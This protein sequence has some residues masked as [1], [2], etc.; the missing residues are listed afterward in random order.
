MSILTLREIESDTLKTDV[1]PGDSGLKLSF[2]KL[3]ATQS[4]RMESGIQ[5]SGNGKVLSGEAKNR[6]IL[7]QKASEYLNQ[8]FQAIRNRRSFNLEPGFQ[9]IENIA[10]VDHL[11]DEI[12]LLAIHLDDRFKYAIH[13]SVNVAVYSVKLAANLGFDKTRQLEI[14]MAGLLHDVGMAVIPDKIIYKQEPLS[15]QEADILKQRPQYSYKILKT[16]G[17]EHAYLAECAAQVYER[18]DGSGYPNGLKAEEINEYAQIIGLLDMYEALIHSRPRRDKMTH[19]SAVKEIINT[20]KTRFQRRHLKAIL[21][22]FTA[23]PVQSYVKLNSDAI[24]RVIETYPDQPM[25][26]KLK[27]IYD[28]QMR[29]VLTDRIISL[30]ENPLLN[31]IDSVPEKEIRQLSQV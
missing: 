19:F 15:E 3:A 31:I 23:F 8:A 28:S 9:I 17:K 1:Q 25:R 5:E 21:S 22:T 30:P 13:H 10:A 2:R 4:K 27:I 18:A 7:Y 11:T 14:G 26:P 20:C 16:F 6:K 24:G 12:F 29:K